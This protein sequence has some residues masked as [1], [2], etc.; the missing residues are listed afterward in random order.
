MKPKPRHSLCSDDML[1]MMMMMM[2][3]MVNWDCSGECMRNLTESTHWV[4]QSIFSSFKTS[5]E[6]CSKSL[7]GYSTGQ[8][9]GDYF[10]YHLGFGF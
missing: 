2:M 3:M 4:F 8:L 9:Y 6:Q 10:I 7:V 5:L 1:M